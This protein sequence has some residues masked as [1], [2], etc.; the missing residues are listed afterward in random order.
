MRPGIG[1]QKENIRDAVR[2]GRSVGKSSLPGELNPKSKLKWHEVKAIRH[3]YEAANTSHSQLA[4]LFNIS[5]QTITSI[6]NFKIWK[7]C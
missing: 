1:T 7:E 3:L 4:L 2:K 5:K 6:I